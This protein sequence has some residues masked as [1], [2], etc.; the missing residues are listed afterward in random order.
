MKEQS[1][2]ETTYTQLREAV[3]PFAKA[4]DGP[5]WGV[6]QASLDELQALHQAAD[7]PDFLIDSYAPDDLLTL[8]SGAL[9]HLPFRL[10]MGLH[11]SVKPHLFDVVD[12]VETFSAY[13]QVGTLGITGG[14]YSHERRMRERA[15]SAL[16]GAI[17]EAAA[18]RKFTAPVTEAI[19][20]SEQLGLVAR[21]SGRILRKAVTLVTHV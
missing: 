5:S 13:Q 6:T 18:D 14:G 21:R 2:T 1:A 8:R 16:S 12:T 17:I 7:H 19:M 15:E 3:E 20:M 11:S 9:F 4:I 10:S